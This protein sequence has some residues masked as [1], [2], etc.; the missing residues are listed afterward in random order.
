MGMGLKNMSDLQ[1]GVNELKGDV[2]ILK[3]K[4]DHGN[5]NSD[6]RYRHHED[7]LERN[8]KN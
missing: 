5:Q 6:E 7:R 1:E 2:E 3:V 8:Y 4:M